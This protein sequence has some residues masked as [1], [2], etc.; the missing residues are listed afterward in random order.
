MTHDGHV[1]EYNF[2]SVAF[3]PPLEVRQQVVAIRAG[4]EKEVEYLDALAAFDGLL[5]DHAVIDVA[6]DLLRRRGQ[7]GQGERQPAQRKCADE[8]SVSTHSLFLA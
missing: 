3:L 2:G 1:A 4:V 6:F 5:R 7:H 8:A